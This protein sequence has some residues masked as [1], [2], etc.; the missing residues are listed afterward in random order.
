MKHRLL[1]CLALVFFCSPAHAAKIG[2][3]CQKDG[4][5]ASGICLDL[6]GSKSSCAGVKICTE[7]CQENAECAGKNVKNAK[8]TGDCDPGTHGGKRGNYCLYVTSL[9]LCKR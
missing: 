7:T 6:G 2:E 5:C 9:A 8:D 4:D 1:I 3:T